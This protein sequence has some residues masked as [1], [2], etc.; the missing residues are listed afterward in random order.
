MALIFPHEA[1]VRAFAKEQKID[2]W[3]SIQLGDL[4]KDDRVHKAVADSLAAIDRENKVSGLEKVRKFALLAE[5]FSAESGTM[6]ESMKLK[7]R[8]I[9]EHYA[10]LLDSLF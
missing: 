1:V 7:R 6:T 3:Q 4:I 9:K 2:D 8:V 5:P 10:A